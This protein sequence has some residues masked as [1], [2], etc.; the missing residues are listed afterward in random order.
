LRR[1]LRQV[2]DACDRPLADRRAIVIRHLQ[3]DVETQ[4]R[5][6]RETSHGTNDVR[7]G[8]W[9]AEIGQLLKSLSDFSDKGQ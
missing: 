1:A 2:A 4:A 9:A 6:D 7:Q 5:Y 8:R 3:E